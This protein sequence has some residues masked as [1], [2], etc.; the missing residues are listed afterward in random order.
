ML[1]QH[2]HNTS[3]R[4]VLLCFA[5]LGGSFKILDLNEKI[6]DFFEIKYDRQGRMSAGMSVSIEV[7]FMPK[8]NED[9]LSDLSFLCSTS[10]FSIPLRC[11][12][13]KVTPSGKRRAKRA[14]NTIHY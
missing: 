1:N 13:Q 8:V 5:S 11:L 10:P 14:S 2:T 4:F 3:L 9:I 6:T 12:T 7:T